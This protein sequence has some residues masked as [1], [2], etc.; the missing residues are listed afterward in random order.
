[1]LTPTCINVKP[2]DFEI[3]A[4]RMLTTQIAITIPGAEGSPRR[5]DHR[6]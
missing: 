5:G 3:A 4:V 6:S 2:M 1:M